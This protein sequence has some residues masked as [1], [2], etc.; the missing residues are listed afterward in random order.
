MERYREIE[1][2]VIA[3]TDAIKLFHRARGLKP[4]SAQKQSLEMSNILVIGGSGFLSQT[5]V[6]EALASGHQVWTITRGQRPVPA[7]ATSLI[8]DRKDREGFAR[9][10]SEARTE[11]DLVIDC[12]GYSPEDL[13]QDV[14]VLTPL[15]RHLIF[16]S[17]DFVYDPARRQFPQQEETDAYI[18][19]GY[20][21]QKREAEIVLLDAQPAAMAWSIVRPSHIYGPGSQLGCLPEHGRDPQLIEQIRARQSLRL[22][23]GG[24]FLQ[25][26]IL[27]RDL[28]RTILSMQGKSEAIGQI[29]NVAGPDIITSREYYQIIARLLGVRVE[30]LEMPVDE[31]ARE[32]PEAA[33]FLCHRFYDLSKLA[34]TA[35]HI[36]AT[37]LE[38]GL[39]QHVSS[40]LR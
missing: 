14:A 35:M 1:K 31:Y 20:G 12:I 9:A 21:G 38:D 4:G 8:A 5:I 11:W 3:G 16:V 22:V 32:H 36:P 33:P 17:T 7:G 40:L 39:R 37:R 34:R 25:H 15:A 19:E 10:V 27:A 30:I 2:D 26:P 18:A 28:A 29:F 24:H 23:G 6:C 13:R